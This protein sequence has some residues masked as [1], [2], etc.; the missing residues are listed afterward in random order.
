MLYDWDLFDVLANPSV[1]LLVAL[2]VLL[3][4]LII[5]DAEHS[6]GPLL[7]LVEQTRFLDLSQL[8]G[9]RCD[10]HSE[11]LAVGEVTNIPL[12]CSA[13]CRF[14]ADHVSGDLGIARSS[15]TVNGLLQ[16]SEELGC[17]S[18]RRSKGVSFALGSKLSLVLT[19]ISLFQ[20]VHNHGSLKVKPKSHFCRLFP[21]V[22]NATNAALY[23]NS[24]QKKRE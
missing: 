16:F 22:K 6:G 17:S 9:G 18:G 3:K 13:D 21:I 24:I 15:I 20:N 2:L 23:S 1:V 10:E 5:R 8:F 14:L 19:R 12:D 11:R 4:F 7:H